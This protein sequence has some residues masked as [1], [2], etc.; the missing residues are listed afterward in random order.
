VT[1]FRHVCEDHGTVLTQCRCADRKTEAKKPCPG[2]PVCP[3]PGYRVTPCELADADAYQAMG[4]AANVVTEAALT[5]R[6]LLLRL[7]FADDHSLCLELD[8]TAT[9]YAVVHEAVRRQAS[10][11]R[12]EDVRSV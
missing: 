5:A 10:T 4:N 3:Q 8:R 11:H 1:H 2:P 12:V 9:Q 6:L 7:G